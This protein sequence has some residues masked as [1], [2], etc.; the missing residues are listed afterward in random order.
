[1]STILLATIKLFQ[2][3]IQFHNQK[4]ERQSF[5]QLTLTILNALEYLSMSNVL[6]GFD[7]WITLQSCN[8]DSETFCYSKETSSGL[9]LLGKTR[10]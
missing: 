1:M 10:K 7:A 9:E 3:W 8:S 2:R 4:E 5:C 6:E